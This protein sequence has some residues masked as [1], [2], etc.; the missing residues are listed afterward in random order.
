[1]PVSELALQRVSEIQKIPPFPLLHVPEP[2]V[3][4]S[5]VFLGTGVGAAVGGLGTLYLLDYYYS[6]R[7]AVRPSAV[8]DKINR[9]TF[10][11]T[12]AGEITGAASGGLLYYLIKAFI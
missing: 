2:I 7:Y 5:M 12:A 11:G 4:G 8:L 10:L 6:R 1:M 3:M 9:I